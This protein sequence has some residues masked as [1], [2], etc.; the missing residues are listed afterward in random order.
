M[1]PYKVPTWHTLFTPS[2]VLHTN[3]YLRGTW[4][5]MLSDQWV[6]EGKLERR[7][8]PFKFSFNE[9]WLIPAPE[10][11]MLSKQIVNVLFQHV[12]S[13]KYTSYLDLRLCKELLIS[14][15]MNFFFKTS[16][17]ISRQLDFFFYHWLS[18]NSFN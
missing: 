1:P 8:E 17:K 4:R 2:H 13:P 7:G 3:N 5:T 12:T 15:R 11:Y 10:K 16:K 14:L 18:Y 6:N 9:L